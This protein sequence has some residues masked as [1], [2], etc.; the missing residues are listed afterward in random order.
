[1]L[2]IEKFA[3]AQ[4]IQLIVVTFPDLQNIEDSRAIISQ[5]V[6]LYQEQNVP[7]LDVTNLIEGNDPQALTVSAVDGHPNERLLQLVAE[8]LYRIIREVE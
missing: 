2:D 7:V 8:E 1:M 5:V 3:E 6:D 4:N